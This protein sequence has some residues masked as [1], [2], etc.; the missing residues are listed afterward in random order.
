MHMQKKIIFL[1]LVLFLIPRQT[2]AMSEKRASQ[3]CMAAGI[4]ASL[5]AAYELWHHMST[6]KQKKKTLADFDASYAEEL[7]YDEQAKKLRALKRESLDAYRSHG[8]YSVGSVAFLSAVYFAESGMFNAFA[9]NNTRGAGSCGVLGTGGGGLYCCLRGFLASRH[10]YDIDCKLIKE[11]EAWNERIEK[12]R[13]EDPERQLIAAVKE[14]DE[15]RVTRLLVKGTDPN[16]ASLRKKAPSVT[17][18]PLFVLPLHEDS[19]VTIFLDLVAGGADLD[20]RN[21]DGETFLAVVSRKNPASLTRRLALMC[22]ATPIDFAAAERT[23]TAPIDYVSLAGFTL[24]EARDGIPPYVRPMPNQYQETC[25]NLMRVR[26]NAFQ[27]PRDMA[28]LCLLGDSPFQK[29][30]EALLEKYMPA[31]LAELVL[32]YYHDSREPIDKYTNELL[33][34]CYTK[35]L[36]EKNGKEFMAIEKLRNSYPERRHNALLTI[37]S[38]PASEASSS[39]E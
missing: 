5:C 22:G 25:R 35:T 23:S 12:E 2:H 31:V 6:I 24:E 16:V 39:P 3:F 32:D 9:H 13:A 21:G 1:F 15:V 11:E 4:G 33:D 20:A 28:A 26:V 34:R 8:M 7:T 38:Q 30:P 17:H 18:Y 14:G 19:H 27:K 36:R 10:I 29:T 37:A